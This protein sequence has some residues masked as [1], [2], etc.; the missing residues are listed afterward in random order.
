MTLQNAGVAAYPHPT[1]GWTTSPDTDG[2]V[3][4][5][6][7]CGTA[8]D[9][10]VTSDSQ[11]LRAT[12]RGPA[13]DGP[14]IFV[15][16][17]SFSYGWMISDDD[18][19]AWRLQSAFPQAQVTNFAQPGFGTTHAVV[20]LMEQIEQGNIPDVCIFAYLP[21]M[22]QPFGHPDRNV[23]NP[24]NIMA[25]TT[26]VEFSEYLTRMSYPRAHL[27]VGGGIS[28]SYV[29]M[30]V[31]ALQGVNPAH[32]AVDTAYTHLVTR[33]LVDVIMELAKT[34]GFTPIFINLL[35]ADRDTLPSYLRDAHGLEMIDG[36]LPLQDADPR[37]RVSRLDIHPNAVSHEIYFDRLREPVASALTARSGR[38]AAGAGRSS[39]SQ[40][41][42]EA[43]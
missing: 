11:G 32:I 25:I 40:D 42:S 6:T 37:Y 19:Y 1:W 23:A 29:P 31:R 28:L 4:G 24:L 14:R 22:E 21:T 33:G 2:V 13:A 12:R 18:T 39:T 8:L 43:V 35:P 38:V 34:H 17:C 3:H 27:K 15:F 9:Y 36:V 16:G 20:Q 10:R 26:Q 30:D 7:I 5:V 41:L